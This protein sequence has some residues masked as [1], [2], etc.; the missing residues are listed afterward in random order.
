V[1]FVWFSWF[2]INFLPVADFLIPSQIE[3]KLFLKSFL[4]LKSVIVIVLD[5]EFSWTFFKYSI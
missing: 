2:L 1:L 3:Q 5:T 4:K